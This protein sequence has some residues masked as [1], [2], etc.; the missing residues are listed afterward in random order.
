MTRVAQITTNVA[1]AA[2]L[3][4]WLLAGLELL[5]WYLK[6]L[7]LAG[8]ELGELGIAIVELGEIPRSLALLLALTAVVWTASERLARGEPV[9]QRLFPL[10]CAGAALVLT[11][12]AGIPCYLIWVRVAGRSDVA[13]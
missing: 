13:P 10:V 1:A 9:F 7:G 11:V 3:A 6:A 4:L 8:A 2:G 5:T 12:L